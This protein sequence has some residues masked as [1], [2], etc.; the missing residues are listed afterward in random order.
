MYKVY[1]AMGDRKSDMDVTERL[2]QA[3]VGLAKDVK[4]RNINQFVS[5]EKEELN[6][7]KLSMVHK[8]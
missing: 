3:V 4:K 1:E 2:T 5:A 6:L 8:P 7:L